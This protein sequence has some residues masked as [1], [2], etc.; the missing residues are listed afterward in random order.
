MDRLLTNQDS[1]RDR[2]GNLVPKLPRSFP[3][4]TLQSSDFSH[5]FSRL[6]DAHARS[7]WFVSMCPHVHSLSIE[8]VALCGTST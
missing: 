6:A 5:A 7:E 4:A 8:G 3:G 2:L 1:K